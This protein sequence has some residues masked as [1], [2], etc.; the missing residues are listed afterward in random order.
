MQDELG[1]LMHHE[2]ELLRLWEGWHWDDNKGGW[3]L[4]PEVCV[5][6]RREKVEYVRRH[7][8]YTS[9]TR[10]ARLRETGKAPVKTG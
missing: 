2:Q 6:A 10:E 4:D 7:M 1:K 5:K 8:M 3:R 9:V